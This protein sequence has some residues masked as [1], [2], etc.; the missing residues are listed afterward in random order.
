MD[1]TLGRL[2]DTEDTTNPF[3]DSEGLFEAEPPSR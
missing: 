1:L 3:K 2:A